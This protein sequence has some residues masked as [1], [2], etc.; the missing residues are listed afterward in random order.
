MSNDWGLTTLVM[1]RDAVGN[2]AK[3][4]ASGSCGFEVDSVVTVKATVK[5]HEEYRG[6]RQTTLSRVILAT[7]TEVA[8]AAKKHSRLSKAA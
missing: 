4:F 2:K 3:W 6:S 7:E 5:D 1:F 8:K